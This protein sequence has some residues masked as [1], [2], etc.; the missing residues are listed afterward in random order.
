MFDFKEKN[1]IV[2]GG[3]SGIGRAISELFLKYGGNV[4]AI[5]GGNDEKAQKF[6]EENSQYGELL[7][8]KKLD[9][10]NFENVEKFFNEFHE[11][12]GEV[13]ILINNAGIRKDSIIAM[14]GKED[15]N[16]V[17]D[18]NLTS[19]YN[20]SKFGVQSMMRERF[21][22]IINITSPSGKFGFKGQSNYAATKAGMV[23]MAK[24]ISKEVGS[25]GITVNCI[26]PGFIDTGFISDLPDEQKKAYKKDIP[27]K[28]FGKPEEVATS[29]IFLSSPMANYING[30]TLEITGGL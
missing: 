22:R 12:T 27:M 8:V 13:A 6:Q 24:S 17:M 9:V 20:M 29:V 1:I 5:Y 4:T 14:M 18:V 26:S 28:R 23:A 30:A 15:W 25:R 3:T 16:R 2:T 21:G 10:S 7:F 19:V 11:K